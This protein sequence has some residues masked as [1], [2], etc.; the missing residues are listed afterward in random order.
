MKKIRLHISIITILITLQGCGA[1]AHVFYKPNDT[2]RQ[3]KA[4]K[5]KFDDTDVDQRRKA[6][7]Q[8]IK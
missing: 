3:G 1:V 6:G 8:F 2:C 7:N 5:G 4:R